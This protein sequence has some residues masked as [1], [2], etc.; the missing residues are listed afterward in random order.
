MD[1]YSDNRHNFDQI[2][3]LRNIKDRLSLRT[4]QKD[5]LDILADIAN[6]IS[7]GKNSDLEND[8]AKIR[9]KYPNFIDFERNFASLCFALATGVGK[10]RLMGAFIA[11]LYL[12]KKSRHF[13]VLAPNTTIYEKLVK[14]FTPNNPKYIFPALKELGEPVIITGDDWHN[15]SLRIDGANKHNQ[16]IVNIFNVDK[17]NRDDGRIRKLNEYLGEAYF[18]YLAGLPDLV[19]LMD[20]AHRYRAKA[21]GRA[22]DEL[23]PILGLELTATPRSV[24]AN[25][26]EFKNVIYHYDLAAALNDGLVKEPAVATR[27]N[28]QPK[29]YSQE[30]LEQIKLEDGI[31]CHENTKAE[32]RL[33]AAQNGRKLV[34]PFMLVVA[35]TTDHAENVR[36]I[37]E[38]DE[39]YGGRYKGR[40]I[41]IDSA[42]KGE[43]SEDATRRLIALEHDD[44]TEIVIHVNKL[45]EGW[46]V[47]NLYTIVPLRASASD[48]LTEQ[49]LGRGLRLPYGERT[50]T[51]SIDG[52]TIIAHDRFNEIIEQAKLPH[53]VIKMRSVIIG[54][55]GNVPDELVKTIECPSVLEMTLLNKK[56]GLEVHE[57]ALPFLAATPANIKITEVILK[58]INETKFERSIHQLKTD[59]V[60]EE[61][62]VKT[63]NNLAQ[64]LDANEN[65]NEIN[66]NSAEILEIVINAVIKDTIEIPNISIVPSNNVSYGFKDFNLNN[67]SEIRY[68]PLSDKILIETIRENERKYLTT[69][70]EDDGQSRLENY[71]IKHL[72]EKS[73][74]DYGDDKILIDKLS[75]Q[76]INRLQ[77]YLFD[78][79]EIVNV[80]SNKGK[81]LADFIF[82]QM[83][84][85]R[86]INEP[87]FD[88]K[89][90]SA[91]SL[92]TT[93][94]IKVQGND[95]LRNF[96]DPVIPNSSTPKFVFNGF[97]KCLYPYQKFDSHDELMFAQLI[98]REDD[99]NLKWFKPWRRQ[100]HIEYEKGHHYEPDFVIE[101]K[102]IKIIAEVKARH[103]IDD[104][105]VQGK[106]KAAKN[107]VDHANQHAEQ[108]G[109]KTW[110]YV[111]VPT[112]RIGQN[113]NLAGIMG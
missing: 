59:D 73:A 79:D 29:D 6:I 88:I 24:G 34:H 40:V 111:I 47:K 84:R 2:K 107:W 31:K 93:M 98:E 76:M 80:L 13:F 26:K 33:Y 7:L 104:A 27:E 30:Q 83:M 108:N 101:S 18:D 1:N 60:K 91:F 38:S 28:F 56:V 19:L 22:V 64:S 103:E 92:P 109:G 66:K 46:D 74:I 65:I 8:L 110:T 81:E 52:L 23:R 5:S 72:V 113:I 85:N 55:T 11:Y 36:K 90:N 99:H 49:T 3:Y 63:L 82:D 50:G 95:Y 100:F 102:A 70:A 9:A 4:P 62:L 45:K 12:M 39:F 58:T 37:L 87:K 86:W 57:D 20:E 44:K 97:S 48:I 75:Q 21:G 68:Q 77:E 41:R 54:A 67:L 10:T 112:D 78:A 15:S 43:E 25:S 61:I 89:I 14:D 16:M 105:K 96:K 35:Q 42:M 69:Q 53:S 17:I 51:V 71:I 32:L 106:A 94:P